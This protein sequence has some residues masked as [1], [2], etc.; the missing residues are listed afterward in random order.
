MPATKRSATT[1]KQAAAGAKQIGRYI[2][3]DPKI[4]H[5]Q[6]TFRGTRIL[7][8]D[9]LDQVASGMSWDRIQK[10]WRGSIPAQAIAEAVQLAKETFLEHA[11]EYV[12][13]AYGQRKP[14]DAAR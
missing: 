5:G 14:V 6:L 7:V 8:A 9:V 2:V 10:E 4:C 12:P 13:P 11:D 3:A 1:Q